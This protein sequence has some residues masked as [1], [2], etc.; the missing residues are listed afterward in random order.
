MA[1]GTK[2]MVINTRERAVSTDINRLQDFQQAAIAEVFRALTMAATTELF[3]RGD[4][5]VPAAA[6]APMSAVI[7][8]GFLCKPQIG[9]ANLFIDGGV[10][11]VVDPDIT[12]G[13]DDSICKVVKDVNGVS[14]PGAISFLAAGAAT[15]IDIVEMARVDPSDPSCIV[16]SASRDIYNPTTG[17]FAATTVT[18]ATDGKVQYRIR[19]GV[20]GSGMPALQS[21]WLPLMVASVPVGATNWDGVTCFDVRPLYADRA[22][23]ANG[24]PAKN[25]I[26]RAELVA[27][28]EYEANG[29]VAART[30]INGRVSAIYAGSI[31][32]GSLPAGGLDLSTNDY[33]VANFIAGMADGWWNLYLAF[34]FALPRWC[35]YTPA[36]AGYRMPAGLCGI[37]I[38]SQQACDYHGAPTGALA[39]PTNLGLGGTTVAALR[40]FSAPCK[41]AQKLI[42]TAVDGDGWYSTGMPV[43]N[44]TVSG[45]ATGTFS[46]EVYK[47]DLVEGTHV[48]VGCKA[49]ELR[50]VLAFTP[51]NSE[52]D[53]TAYFEQY[54]ETLATAQTDTVGLGSMISTTANISILGDGVK[55]RTAALVA[56]M[57]LAPSWPGASGVWSL[58]TWHFGFVIGPSSAAIVAGTA[59]IRVGRYRI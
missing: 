25:E 51:A 31:V 16:E 12:P 7:L 27:G 58:H 57:S 55:A 6:A 21:G 40:V 20:E 8:N 56:R 10:M 37:P 4:G 48:P 17:L 35:R 13:A 14:T 22:S 59:S 34:P 54:I 5:V 23:I 19:R 24:V 50:G 2:R 46:N 47:F 49:V 9:S 38:A 26:S 28:F 43:T 30:F 42:P 11:I 53:F 15:R 1:S 52:W 36:S 29:G 18:K 44:P 39:L 41:A 33:A 45:H 32:G 3:S